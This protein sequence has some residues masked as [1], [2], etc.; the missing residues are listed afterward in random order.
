MELSISRI[1]HL[2]QRE[3][4]Q[5][6]SKYLLGISI[7]V[8]IA[9]LIACLGLFQGFI[10]SKQYYIGVSMAFVVG[11]AISTSGFFKEYNKTEVGYQ[12]M[13]L[14]ASTLE[15][16]VS[17]WLFCFIIYPMA[18]FL[19][20]LAGGAILDMLSFFDLPIKGEIYRLEVLGYL[21]KIHLVVNSI[22][23]LGGI[24]FKNVAFFKTLVSVL[25]I[26]TAISLV[27]G[28]VTWMFFSYEATTYYSNGEM[29]SLS[30]QSISEHG[31]LFY[32][33]NTILVLF[34]MVVSYFKLK[35]REL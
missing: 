28:G 8:V 6:S 26:N 23:F 3:L 7:G 4:I 32:L 29:E 5:S 14:P 12:L 25:V 20:I 18:S 35:E 13:I 9:M 33:L 24:A 15:K 1:K 22:F 27:V 21:F 11:G 31:T 2:I 19:L 16:L 34:L 17:S 30:Y 10:S